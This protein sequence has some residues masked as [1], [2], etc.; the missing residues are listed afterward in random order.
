[1][2]LPPVFL[3]DGSAGLFCTGNILFVL[4]VLR[5]ISIKDIIL[6]VW[7]WRVGCPEEQLFAY[8]GTVNIP[9]T[10]VPKLYYRPIMQ[11][12]VIYLFVLACN[13]YERM[14]ICQEDDSVYAFVHEGLAAIQRNDLKKYPFWR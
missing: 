2:P 13:S 11:G 1:M 6:I 8:P 7:P 14:A 10:E 4:T 5:F 9:G 3:I 12:L